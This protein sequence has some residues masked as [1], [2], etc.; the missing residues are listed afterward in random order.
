M[1]TIN[2]LASVSALNAGDSFVL[3][4]TNNGDSRRVSVTTL[5]SY[6]NANLTD[7]S[8][9][10]AFNTQRS[11]P[12]ATGFDVAVTNGADNVHL[13]LTPLAGY[14]AGDI[15]L[16][17]VAAAADKQEVLVNTTQAVTT[18]TVNGNGGTVIGAPT[19]LAAGDF[20]RLKYDQPFQTW[21]R[22]G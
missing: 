4:S 12:N 5:M 19:T 14:A 13:I 8:S 9:D 16:P 20:F 10:L 7:P 18:F 17:A 2:K 15:T 22:V 6:V 11:S 21:Y 1:T 3:W